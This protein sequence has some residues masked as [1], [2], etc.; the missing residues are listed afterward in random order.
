MNYT[1]LELVQTVLSEMDSDSVNSINDTIESQQVAKSI[2]TLY[3]DLVEEFDIDGKKKL[4]QLDASTDV[5]KPTHMY[6]P[7]DI[8]ELYWLKYNVKDTSDGKDEW[9]EVKYF[10]PEEF[11]KIVL[12]RNNTDP[13][14]QSVVDGDGY[15]FYI[16]NDRHPSMWTSFDDRTIIFDAYKSSLDTTLQ[17]SKTLCYGY[18]YPSFNLEDDAVPV[19]PDHLRQL[20]LREAI[21]YCTAIYKQKDPEK[22]RRASK[23]RASTR[24]KTNRIINDFFASRPDFGRK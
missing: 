9:R 3:Y 11:I 6:L 14:V 12:G 24:A 21:D 18:E 8:R 13:N 23:L 22:H 10:T 17:N 16:F 5:A 20:L 2:Q 1:L 19:I 4:F 15:Y 7:S